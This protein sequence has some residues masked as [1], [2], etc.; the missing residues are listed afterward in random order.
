M[1]NLTIEAVTPIYTHERSEIFD[2]GRELHKLVSLTEL[3]RGSAP[4][5]AQ[6][7]RSVARACN[8]LGRASVPASATRR[9]RLLE[10]AREHLAGAGVLLILL[11]DVGLMEAAPFDVARSLLARLDDKLVTE[12]AQCVH[13]GGA[14]LALVLERDG[15]E[16]AL[17]PGGTSPDAPGAAPSR[18]SQPA[19]VN[20]ASNGPGPRPTRRRSRPSQRLDGART[21]LGAE[22]S[23]A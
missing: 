14:E 10:S 23:P 19:L 5:R 9:H 8:Q 20:I 15:R 13:G 12:L 16:Q 21:R 11:R 3:Q 18:A 7:I 4:Y 17:A 22:V 6:L 1:S 2:L